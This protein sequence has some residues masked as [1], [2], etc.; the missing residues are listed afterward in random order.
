MLL[1]LLV[2]VID[3]SWPIMY[4]LNRA[5]KMINM[6]QIQ[7]HYYSPDQGVVVQKHG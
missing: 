3:N 7:R 1:V 4:L 2:I 5:L 6:K